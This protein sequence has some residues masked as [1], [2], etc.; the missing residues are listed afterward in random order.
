MTEEKGTVIEETSASD[1]AGA[2]ADAEPKVDVRG[3]MLIPLEGGDYLLRPAYSA[4]K[5]IETQLKPRTVMELAGEAL[6]GAISCEDLGV[7]CAEF[8][9]AEGRHNKDAGP[10]YTHAS[11]AKLAELIYEAGPPRIT[12]RVAIVLMGAA[13]GGYTAKGEVRPVAP[14]AA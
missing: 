3:Q 4:I 8:M 5:A 2:L 11:A 1:P 14:K 12:A 6:R 9:K 10:S 7:I 13:T